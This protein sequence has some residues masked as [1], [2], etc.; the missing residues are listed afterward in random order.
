V[1]PFDVHD[2]EF[3]AEQWYHTLGDSDLV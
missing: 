3:Y 1:I 2:R